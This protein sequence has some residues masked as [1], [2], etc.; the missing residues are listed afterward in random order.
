MQRFTRST[1]IKLDFLAVPGLTACDLVGGDDA[2]ESAARAIGLTI[3]ESFL[4]RAD[5]VREWSFAGAGTCGGSWSQAGQWPPD[6]RA[7]GASGIIGLD[8]IRV[9]D[10]GHQPL[11][12]IEKRL[13]QSRPLKVVQVS[14][15]LHRNAARDRQFAAQPRPW[16]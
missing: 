10:I 14:C 4:L 16:A 6:R 9:G 8:P 13:Q 1:L 3:P 7:G 5:E 2:S 12:Q 11:D 15:G